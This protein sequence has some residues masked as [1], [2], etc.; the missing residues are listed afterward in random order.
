MEA[1]AL[2]NGGNVGESSIS[3]ATEAIRTEAPPEIAHLIHQYA[4]TYQVDPYQMEAVINCESGFN[5]TI[6]SQHIRE[7]GTQEQSYG[8]VQIHLPAHPDVSYEQ[9]INP[10]FA[11]EFMAREFANDNEEIWTCYNQLYGQSD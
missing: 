3:E 6:Q 9:A 7:D 8:L 1:H 10:E 4:E 5:S 2:V 11:I